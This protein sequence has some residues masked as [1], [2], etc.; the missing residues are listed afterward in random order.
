M[1]RKLLI[2]SILVV[3]CSALAFYVFKT[4]SSEQARERYFA[5]GRQY[6]AAGKNAEAA[7]TFRNAIQ[8]D[9]NFAAARYELGLVLL[10]NREFPGAFREFR[11]AVELDPKLIKARRQ[12]GSLYL[13]ER[14]IAA[15]KEQL[16]GIIERD[17]TALEG[18]YLAAAIALAENDPDRALKEL[19]E[20]ASRAEVEKSPDLGE[21]YIEQGNINLLRKA[22][23]EAETAYKKVLEL[24]PKLLRAREG[25]AAIYLAKGEEE[26]ARQELITAT[27]ADPENEA[28]WHRLGDF[29]LQTK[30][31][32][33]YEKFYREL[34]QEKPKWMIARKKMADILLSKG[35]LKP[36][37]AYV[38]EILKAQPGDTYTLFLRGRIYLIEKD[39]RKAYDDLMKVTAADPKFAPGFYYLAVAQIRLNDVA[40]ARGSLL[41][42]LELSPNAI[43]PRL[44]LAEVY[45]NSGDA[46]AAKRETDFILQ[47][48]PENRIALLIGGAAELRKGDAGKALTLLRK[49]QAQDSK[50]ARVYFFLGTAFLL[51]KNY[52]QA[53]KEFE[54]SLN[55]DPDR[56]EALNSFALAMVQHGSR[57][58]AIE[59]TEK[60]LSKTKM[61]AEVYQLLGQLSLDGKEFERGIQHL[62]RAIEIKPSLVSAYYLIGNAYIAQNKIDQAMDEYQKI[63]EKNP[64]DA[65]AHTILGVLYNQKQAYAKAN[66]HYERALKIDPHFAAAA[67]N[68]AWNYTEHGG[69]LDL[70]LPLAQK[71]RETNPDSPQ[72]LDTLG[73]IYYK[74]GMF[75]NAM[76]LLKDSSEKLK[77]GDPVVLYHLGMAYH[78][79]G[80]KAEA[81]DTLN[82]ALA[83]NKNFPGA[84]EARKV[85]AEKRDR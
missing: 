33:E 9:P 77:N 24:N 7:I 6:A 20:A 67:N 29:Y 83:L 62:R 59:R 45:L 42:A 41:K 37:K 38:E 63:I 74:R 85:L 61:Q 39:F 14:N 48:M 28:L 40:Q 76:V 73:W 54:Q 4:E 35:D 57:K 69:N 19:R 32:G 11:R 30:R 3:I 56:I 1:R 75:D 53:A 82:K 27:K 23:G 10:Q 84:D 21:I 2:L 58:T 5:Q 25:L 68:L 31:L 13:L 36:A 65:G 71:A 44:T 34:V 52:A 8:I 60:H 70:A 79:S 18:R 12:L 66:Q 15:A 17:S 72:V 47:H 78:R 80:R 81:R 16:A 51:Q 49:A 55:L 46:E 64:S 22:W 43:E 50:D 26:K